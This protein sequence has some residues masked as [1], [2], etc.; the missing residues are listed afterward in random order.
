MAKKPP[1][2]ASTTAKNNCQ[3]MSP[4][5]QGASQHLHGIAEREQLAH[6]SLTMGNDNRSLTMCE[7]PP[8]IDHGS[9]ITLGAS[10]KFGAITRRVRGVPG[11]QKRII[12]HT[13]IATWPTFSVR[14][15]KKLECKMISKNKTTIWEVLMGIWGTSIFRRQAGGVEKVIFFIWKCPPLSKTALGAIPDDRA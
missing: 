5:L 3:N 8:S 7:W 10:C 14:R 2:I 6:D 1:C 11:V 13:R 4:R 9:L 12:C 15:A